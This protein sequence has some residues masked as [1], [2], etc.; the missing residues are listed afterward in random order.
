MKIV[1]FFRIDYFPEDYTN[2][3]INS[4]IVTV[5]KRAP[6]REDGDKKKCHPQYL[7]WTRINTYEMKAIRAMEKAVEAKP[8]SVQ[9]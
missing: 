6:N 8:N 9:Q 7:K 3:E 2:S 4:C 1:N 5:I